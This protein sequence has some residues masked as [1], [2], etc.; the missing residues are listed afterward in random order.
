MILFLNCL[1]LVGNLSYL[2]LIQ[3]KDHPGFLE[4][5]TLSLQRG[6]DW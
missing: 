3:E 2:F 1:Q 6:I 5:Q 4:I